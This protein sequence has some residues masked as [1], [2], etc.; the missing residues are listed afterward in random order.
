VI[1][2]A[3][4]QPL[5]AYLQARIL[6]PLGMKDTGFFAEPAQQSRIAEAFA[7]DPDSKASVRLL[8]VRQKPKY[9]AGG[10]GLVSTAADYMRFAQMLLN[11]G[12]LGGVRILSRKTVDFMASDH[13][14]AI[15]GPSPGYGFGLG[16]AVRLVNG[17]SAV[18]G[19]TGD[20]NWAGYGG[21]YFWIDPKERLVAVWMMQAPNQRNYYRE[22][23]RN[24]VYGALD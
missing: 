9:L 21:T 7:T 15:R 4:G 5:D 16:F 11:G 19:N 14:G 6:G 20:Y 12:E 23:Y 22:L 8:N 1:E 17:L 2:R 18:N 10:Q 13:L 24:M 3:T